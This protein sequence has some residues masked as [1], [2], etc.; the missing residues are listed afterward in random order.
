MSSLTGL[1][2]NNL[3]DKYYLDKSVKKKVCLEN[4][5]NSENQIKLGDNNIFKVV[6]KN[7]VE[8]NLDKCSLCSPNLFEKE[9]TIQRINSGSSRSIINVLLEEKFNIFNN[10]KGDLNN[11]S[12]VSS[13]NF[14]SPLNNSLERDEFVKSDFL[15]RR[16]SSLISSNLCQVK[17]TKQNT[18][19]L[20][21]NDLQDLRDKILQRR[22]SIKLKSSPQ[23][24]CSNKLFDQIYKF[25]APKTTDTLNDNFKELIQRNRSINQQVKNR[26]MQT[27]CEQIN[28]KKYL[29][30]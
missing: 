15:M 25:E 30:I 3:I 19:E 11:D 23:P 1:E 27:R 14:A 4:F 24:K 16:K 22:D 6:C 20:F 29:N 2:L 7:C 9:Q 28:F 21:F 17:P 26:D 18:S 8:L 12:S 13:E 10:K 5:K